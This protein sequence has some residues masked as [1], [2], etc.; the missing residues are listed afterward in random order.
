MVDNN[1]LQLSDITLKFGGLTVLD[2]VSLEVCS[3][4]LLAL[5][6]PNGAGK[7]S[8]LNSISG[9]Y[10]IQSGNILLGGQNIVG[11]KPHKIANMGI[12]R[13]FQNAELF[14]RMSVLDNLL[15]GCHASIQSNVFAECLF[16]PSARREEVRHRE[17]VEEIIDFVELDAYRHTPVGSLPFGTQKIVG[18][19]R[20]LVHD[21]KV[22]LL[23]E[24]C[25]GLNQEG[26]EDMARH[27]MRI[28]HEKDIAL[29][30]VEHD[31]Q[32]VADLADR[33]YVLNY[34]KYLAEGAPTEVLNDHKV[35][36]AYIGH[37][38][39]VAATAEV[40]F[41]HGIQISLLHQFSEAVAS[42]VDKKTTSGLLNHLL[43][44]SREHF[45]SE[46]LL[47]RLHA[48][49]GRENHAKEHVK[50]VEDISGAIRYLEM[51]ESEQAAYKAVQVEDILLQHIGGSDRSFAYFLHELD[52]ANENAKHAL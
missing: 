7:T 30:W 39:P 5:I 6:G 36:E 49:P 29:I 1:S 4:E 18:F 15:V 46:E 28:Q 32:M 52:D 37:T 40:D 31:M 43:N 13:T 16:L 17:F 47:M 21:P 9:V 23:D 25:A 11:M 44:F 19:A 45:S 10:R 27:I 24:P 8:I 34:G 42:G 14:P 22:L 26:R 35:I 12:A 38:T 48:Y 2:S 51:G 50:I 20:A 41:E 3:G 33:L